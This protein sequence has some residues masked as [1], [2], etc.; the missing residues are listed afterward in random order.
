[1]PIYFFAVISF[2]SIFFSQEA[3]ALVSSHSQGNEG[4]WKVELKTTLERGKVEPNENNSSFQ[5]AKINIYE[6]SAARFF[7]ASFGSRHFVKLQM[8]AFESGREEAGGRI[9]HERDR[10]HAVTQAR[11][12]IS[13]PGKKLF[14]LDSCFQK[15]N[16]TWPAKYVQQGAIRV[17]ELDD[18]LDQLK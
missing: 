7:G 4:D 16:I 9:F 13:Q 17:K 5:K 6:A 3:N 2:V 1:M 18:I 15:K 8:R 10:G 14:I 12:C 11:A